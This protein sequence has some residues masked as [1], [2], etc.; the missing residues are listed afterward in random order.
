M[1][2]PQHLHSAAIA[3]EDQQHD[4]AE[5]HLDPAETVGGLL[6]AVGADRLVQGELHRRLFIGHGFSPVA[7]G[8][9]LS[10][11]R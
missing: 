3:Y 7:T 9:A 8:A 1:Q 6:L 2:S 4:A 11:R 10:G 5:H